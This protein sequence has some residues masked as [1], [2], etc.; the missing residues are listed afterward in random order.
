MTS[1][2]Y[3]SVSQSGV[4]ADENVVRMTTAPVTPDAPAAMA[5]NAP[6]PNEVA[7]DPNPLLGMATRQLAS[8]WH[9]GEQYSPSW[10]G[11][12]DDADNHNA[13]VDRRISSSGTA[14]AREAAGVFGH[15]T[16]KYAEGIESVGDLR[17]GGSFGNEY[18]KTVAKDIQS[19]TGDYMTA[20][21][22]ADQ[23]TTSRVAAES[24]VASRQASTAAAYRS[25]WAGLQS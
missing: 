19:N 21:P 8:T 10:K 3:G 7:T 15:G 18:F 23:D 22:G 9:E 14:A 17:E 11:Q 4:P 1:L 16:L 6:D 13:I 2:L 25:M 20:T 24:K 12:V 5:D